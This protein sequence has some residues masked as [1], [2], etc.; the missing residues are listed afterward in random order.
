MNAG[1]DFE[2]Q[3]KASVPPGVYYERIKDPAQSFFKQDSLRFSPAN[4]YDCFMY[5]YPTLFTIELKSTKG[6]SMTFYHKDCE[7]D[8]KKHTYMIKKCQIEGLLESRKHK[9]IVSGLVLNFRK[10]AHTYFIDIFDFVKMVNELE[11]KSFNECD[12]QN[13]NAWVIPQKLKRT[14]YTYDISKFIEVIGGRT[15]DSK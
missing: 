14:N 15:Y 3:W 7:S 12:L 2:S 10:T 4:K 1:K 8:G 5:R 9:G 6:T 11:K 13:Y